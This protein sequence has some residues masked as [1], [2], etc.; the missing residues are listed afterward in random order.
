M[1]IQYFFKNILLLRYDQFLEPL[2]TPLV[3][4]IATSVF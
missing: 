2:S 1:Y 3:I 4:Y